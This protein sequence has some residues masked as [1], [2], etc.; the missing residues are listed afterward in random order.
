MSRPLGAHVGGF[1]AFVIADL[2]A[3]HLP[4]RMVSLSGS[5]ERG[6]LDPRRIAELAETWAQIREAGRAWSQW[7]AS[8]DESTEV[9]PAEMPAVS[10]QEIDTATAAGLLDVTE[11]RVRQLARSG[12][13]AARK[14]GGVWLV[15]RSEIEMRRTAA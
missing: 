13:I 3:E 11:S 15:S 12:D 7:R 9:L 1:S 5:A 4:A 8:V 10:L 2:L 14:A 6:R